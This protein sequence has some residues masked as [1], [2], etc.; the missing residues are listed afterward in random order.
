M[1]AVCLVSWCSLLSSSE[2]N[3]WIV[4]SRRGICLCRRALAMGMAAWCGQTRAG[5]GQQGRV[6]RD[7][8]HI[9]YPPET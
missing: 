3:N 4:Y 7:G 8:R 9:V 5:Q 2:V 6:G 1:L